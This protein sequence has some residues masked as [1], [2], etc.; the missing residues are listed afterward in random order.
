MGPGVLKFSA[1]PTGLA[2]ALALQSGQTINVADVDVGAQGLSGRLSIDGLSAATPLKVTLFDGFAVGLTVF[3]VTLSNG[4]LS[5]SQ[6]VGQ[7]EV[8]F[9]TDGSGKRKTVDV[10]LGFDATGGFSVAL[11]ASESVNPTTPDGLVQLQYAIGGGTTIEIDVA[12]FEVDPLPGGTYRIVISG[13]LLLTTLGLQWPAFELRGLGIDSKGNISIDG[14]WIDL[15][16]QTGL[17]F[18]GFHMALHK[19]GFGSD[20][21][22]RWIG[23]NGDIH[24]VEGV[25]LGGSIHGLRINLDTG[26]VSFEGVSVDFSISGVLS[27]TGEIDHIH[28]D[29]S[30][31]DDLRK[32][33]LLPS[34]FNHIPAVPG[35]APRRSTSSPGRWTSISRRFLAAFKSKE[36]SSS[37][38]LEACRS[39]S[40]TS[41]SICRRGFLF[42][43][44]S[45][46]MASRAWSPPTWSPSRSRTT[47]GG[48]GT[49]TRPTQAEF[50]TG[51]NPDY[52]ATDVSKWLASPMQGALALGAGATIGT[53]VD[54]GFTVS[55]AI[56]FIP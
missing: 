41:T 9:L 34:I 50:D 1:D 44:T 28:V 56:T 51:A 2:M 14:G 36:N 52:D 17:D 16:S 8:P 54:D 35:K 31:P 7:F 46:S 26:A 21:S 38:I 37:A 19:L 30:G 40:S 13:R 10:E 3:D 42:S 22:G 32:A 15:P 12:S 29:A 11:A 23:F 53:S 20:G 55:A 45:P 33:G 43:S 18:H 49:N 27:I 6:V 4:G 39:F 47:H 5:Q 24:L 48:S 25:P